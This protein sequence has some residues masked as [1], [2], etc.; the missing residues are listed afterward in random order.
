MSE[1]MNTSVETTEVAEP[2][3]ESVETTEVAE[4]STEVAS[5]HERTEAERKADAKFAE[6]RRAETEAR[7]EAEKYKAELERLQSENAAKQEAFSELTGYSENADYIAVALAT[8]MPEEEAIAF[9]EAQREKYDLINEVNNLKATNEALMAEK[10][11]ARLQAAI[12]EQKALDLAELKAIDSSITSLEELG[13]DFAT[14]LSSGMDA[15]H[16]YF[17]MKAM[18]EGTMA[19]PPADIGLVNKEAPQKDFYTKEEVD[20]MSSEE[21]KRNYKQIMAS[22]T[23]WSR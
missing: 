1:E 17:A 11:E 3:T 2:S 21:K 8:G 4:P 7:K 12:T 13:T 18:K 19:K 20:A 10:E 9:A 14:F 23:R 6:M 16:A 15:K 22:L 5:T